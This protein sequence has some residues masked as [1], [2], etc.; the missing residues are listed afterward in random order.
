MSAKTPLER[1]C[2]CAGSAAKLAG[3]IGV[4][5][6]TLSNWKDR[7]V[8]IERCVSIESATGGEVTR[9]ELRPDDW[10]AIWPELAEPDPK[11]DGK[12]ERRKAARAS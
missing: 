7:G 3:L 8:P 11:W 2:D 12:T 1:A 6:Q 5:Q 10:Q 4:S 9:K